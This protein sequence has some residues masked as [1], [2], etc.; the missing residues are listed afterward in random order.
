MK[1]VDEILVVT[2]CILIALGVAL[3]SIPAALIV[4]GAEMIALGF[5]IAKA[6]VNVLPD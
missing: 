6:N 2:G 1:H 4:A 3:W 5:L